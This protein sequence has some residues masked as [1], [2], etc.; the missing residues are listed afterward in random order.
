M[1]KPE[2]AGR[3]AFLIALAVT[4]LT[5]CWQFATVHLVYN[6]NWTSLY[7]A[8]DQVPVP[9][10]LADEHVY[11]F[12]NVVGYDGEGYH[13]MAHDP[14]F[15][16]DYNKYFDLPRLRYRRILVSGLAWLL[17]FGRDEWVDRAYYSIILGFVFLGTYWLGRWSQSHERSPL[18]ALLFIA[19]P[20]ALCSI[21]LMTID[22]ALAAFTAGLLWYSEQK[23][24]GKL[25]VVLACA[26]L[27]R[28][29]GILLLIGWCAWL[30][31]E[32]KFLFAIKY[33]AAAIPLACWMLFVSMH[34]EP[35]GQ[36]WLSPI[37]LYGILNALVHPRN[38]TA[39]LYH[40]I[41]VPMDR[42]AMIGMLIAL[43]LLFK[44]ALRAGT[45]DYK[46]F[47]GLTFAGLALFL[48]GGAVWPEVVAFGRNFTPLLLIVAV[49]G[50]LSGNW[51]RFVPILLIDPRILVIHVMQAVRIVHAVAR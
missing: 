20:A 31:F 22:I 5:F 45:R 49:S 29:T 15:R 14:F 24:W 28:E 33:A 25:F 8:G 41:L 17:A 13:V 47:A 7:Y 12:P 34:T 32:R 4:A 26:A 16:R 10:E 42:I 3:T 6:D 18:W 19:T 44:D 11:L 46:T 40:N 37:P 35:S 30:I 51:W 36:V 9:K 23:A 2:H 1:T 48:A 50:I 27:T 39:G 38:Y 21:S 43:A